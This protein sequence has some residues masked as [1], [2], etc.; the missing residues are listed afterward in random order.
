MCSFIAKEG[1]AR[2]ALHS[3]V[4]RAQWTLRE[5]MQQHHLTLYSASRVESV[6]QLASFT[7]EEPLLRQGDD[8]S[9]QPEQAQQRYACPANE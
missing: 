9:F 2:G 3:Y 1:L 7:Y 8:R 6:H 4:P 5:P